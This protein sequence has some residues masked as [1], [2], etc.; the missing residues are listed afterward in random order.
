MTAS[1]VAS[2]PWPQPTPPYLSFGNRALRLDREPDLAR[3]IYDDYLDCTAYLYPD[4]AAAEAGEG[5]GGSC[6]FI[7][8]PFE[9]EPGKDRIVPWIV[10]N[11]HVVE[12]GGWTIRVNTRDG[13]FETIDTNEREWFFHPDGD[14]LAVRPF[15]YRNHHKVTHIG[16]DELLTESNARAH[17]VGPGDECLVAGRFINH[18]G[19]QRNTPTVRFGQ[20]AQE[21]TEKII[22]YGREQESYLVEI[23]S[24]GG[25]SGSPVFVILDRLFARPI[26]PG[27][28]DDDGNKISP[29]RW[30]KTSWMLGV[31]WCMIPSW[32]PVCDRHGDPLPNGWQ[33]PANTGMMG[34][35]PAWKLLSLLTA[36]PPVL[37]RQEEIEEDV[38]QQLKRGPAVIRTSQDH[39]ITTAEAANSDVAVSPPATDENPKHR[40][41]FTA[42]LNAAAKTPPQD[43]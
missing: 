29:L 27:A 33:V 32:E 42:L 31:N 43:D 25:Y 35:V 37:A 26:T 13:R 9:T 21:P 3:R 6:F 36:H 10:T 40:E 38:M 22:A 20:I 4:K 5:F 12:N 14:D 17:A 11:R 7:G 23:R 24:I 2:N 41:D 1:R 28:V 8:V 30:K 19:R 39:R 34:V 18:E 16:L 15:A